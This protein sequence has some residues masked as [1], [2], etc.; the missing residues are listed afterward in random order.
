MGSGI[1]RELLDSWVAAGLISPEQA[2]AIWSWETS[3]ARS[4]VPIAANTS[5]PGQTPTH[6]Q[7]PPPDGRRVSLVAEV[8][9]Y[10][11][12]SLALGALF[13][14]TAQYWNSFAARLT[15]SGAA[16]VL[17]LAG[18]WWLS[19][20]TAPQVRRLGY[21]LL[22]LGTAA[23]GLFVGLTADNWSVGDETPLVAGTGAALVCG[24]AAW[25]VRRTVLQ[26]IGLTLA[27]AAFIPAA[28]LL[29][30]ES[31]KEWGFAGFGYIALGA[32]W[33]ILGQTG[34]L[35]PREAAWVMGSLA[36]ISGPQILALGINDLN[37]GGDAYLLLGGAVSLVLLGAGVWLGRGT[38]LGFGAAG[39]VIFTPQ[40]LYASFEDTIGAPITLLIAGL[41]L[42]AMSAVVITL[43]SRRRGGKADRSH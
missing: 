12:G 18:G 34:L 26:L 43:R 5:S 38:P 40:F 39:I 23:I 20:L 33:C 30:S 36:L 7:A 21:F 27:L 6:P 31:S 11:G 24:L 35:K 29:F 17:C 32:L 13:A 3:P 25:W 9:G 15:L 14:L 19:S 4:R 10:V 41:L 8:L 22:F 1:S 2:E 28:A 42:V 16:T 37:G